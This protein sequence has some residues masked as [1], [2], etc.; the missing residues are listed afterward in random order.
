M[1]SPF[2][3]VRRGRRSLTALLIAA[4]ACVVT[5]SVA[6]WSQP[7][8]RAL[9]ADLSTPSVAPPSGS[10]GPASPDPTATAA[11]P[12]EPPAS[13][14]TPAP[15][16]PPTV[17][18][19]SSAPVEPAF[20]PGI[21]AGR[22]QWLQ[23]RLD[24]LRARYAIPG[25]SATIILA[26][27]TTW[28]GVSG[29]ADVKRKTPVEADTAFAIASVTK[30][31]TAALILALAEEGRLDLDARV[32]TILPGVR[33]AGKATVRQLLDHTSGLPDYFLHGKIDRALFGERARRW[34]S[35]EAFRYVGKPIFPAGKGWY[36]S[37][38]NYR[39]LGLI[40]E[41]VGGRPLGEQL[42]ERFLGPL[43]L[44]RTWDQVTDEPRGPVAHGYRVTGTRARP[45][46]SDLA[47]GTGVAPF[48]SVVTAAGGAGS[49]A[50]SSPDVARWARALYRGEV[51]PPA[52]VRDM[53]ADARRTARFRP[54]VPYG[55]GVQLV[56]L[57]GRP[58]L[59]HSGRLAGF[60]SVVRYLPDEGITIAVLTNESKQ[61]PGVIARALL[62]VVSP[63]P[64]PS[65]SASAIVR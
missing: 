54:R 11:P 13:P 44:D 5:V 33:I 27:G 12:S 61:D 58:A 32:T 60:R 29:L 28:T 36:Y 25:V 1:T 38:T 2:R 22:A 63:P 42:R 21:G 15:T 41:E 34:T 23:S 56:P 9:T 62:H 26:D 37:N 4:V 31:Y 52:T 53:I 18:P 45:R 19:P 8:D 40:A 47:D 48:S 39:L 59:G 6:A 10:V 24:R 30:T 43:G 20:E 17:A 51:L 64:E 46:F 14:V 3:A 50:A 49:L 7:L 57:D 65:P 16:A 35:A 55:L